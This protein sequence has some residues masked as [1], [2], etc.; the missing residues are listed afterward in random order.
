M[1]NW[2]NVA[3]TLTREITRLTAL[4]EAADSLNQ[5]AQVEQREKELNKLVS[6][7]AKSKEKLTDEVKALNAKADAAVSDANLRVAQANKEAA[8]LL[9]KIKAD[10]KADV[11][12]IIAAA[13]KKA[14]VII[15]SAQSNLDAVIAET[16]KCKD[17][18]DKILSEVHA[19]ELT[20]ASTNEKIEDAEKRFAQANAKIAKLLQATQ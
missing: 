6:D 5:L 15:S 2:K 12:K 18:R 7:L 11:D 8:E 17:A 14:D 1:A 13:N 9:D 19:A 10:G 3:D 16:A 4:Q 20:L